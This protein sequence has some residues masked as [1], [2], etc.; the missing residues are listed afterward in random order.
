MN[1]QAQV[2]S[3]IRWD[4]AYPRF[5]FYSQSDSDKGWYKIQIHAK[6]DPTTLPSSSV[7]LPDPEC[8]TEFTLV[9]F[10]KLTQNQG[11]PFFETE[12]PA[13]SSL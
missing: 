6:L 9:V 7:T 2:P 12:L 8:V 5:S 11:P 4:P 1:G 13:I 3:F 10:G